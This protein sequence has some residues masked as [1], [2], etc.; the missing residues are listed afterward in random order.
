MT[1]PVTASGTCPSLRRPGTVKEEEL[2]E[3]AAAVGPLEAA[4]QPAAAEDTGTDGHASVP[5]RHAQAAPAARSA[6]VPVVLTVLARTEL[7]VF[8]LTAAAPPHCRT[9]RRYGMP[10]R[11]GAPC[12]ARDRPLVPLRRPVRRLGAVRPAAPVA[13]PP[14]GIPGPARHRCISSGQRRPAF[15]AGQAVG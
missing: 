9:A 4:V 15:W 6:D 3:P 7:R 2:L 8:R 12:P 13:T 10:S 1:V 5:H 14:T 11:R